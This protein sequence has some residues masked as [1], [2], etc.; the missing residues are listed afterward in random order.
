MEEPNPTERNRPRQES[1]MKAPMS[2][3]RLLVAEDKRST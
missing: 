2:G 3:V 1:A